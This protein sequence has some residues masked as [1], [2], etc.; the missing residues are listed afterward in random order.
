MI[1]TLILLCNICMQYL[2]ELLAVHY[3]HCGM[4]IFDCK[5]DCL[6][7]HGP[8]LAS[9]EEVLTISIWNVL[10]SSVSPDE[11]LRTKTYFSIKCIAS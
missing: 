6:T 11:G 1:V 4:S 9:P 3:V 8:W 10:C 5:T 7:A 2:M